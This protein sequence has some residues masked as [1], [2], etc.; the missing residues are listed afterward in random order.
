MHI[1][2][3]VL[4]FLTKSLSCESAAAKGSGLH[5][6]RVADT[7]EPLFARHDFFAGAA[8]RKQRPKQER[9][10]QHGNARMKTLAASHNVSTQPCC[11]SRTL[12]V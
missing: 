2:T 6:P 3:N 12:S 10:G 11:Y 8:G 1:L 9:G 5:R 7:F 4:H